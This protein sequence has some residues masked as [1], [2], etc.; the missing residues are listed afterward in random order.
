MKHLL[1]FIL[2]TAILSPIAH[3]SSDDECTL[4]VTYASRAES[5]VDDIN[6]KASFEEALVRSSYLVVG[7]NADVT[8]QIHYSERWTEGLCPACL[9]NFGFLKVKGTQINVLGRDGV[10]IYSRSLSSK[11]G[12]GSIE[13]TVK[14]MAKVFNRGRFNCSFR[15]I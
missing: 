1:L 4:A 7:A 6:V 8:V 9:C 12:R 5:D 11:L 2:V 10:S 15:R 13:K 3:A 14:E